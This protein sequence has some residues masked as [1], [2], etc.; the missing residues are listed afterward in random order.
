MADHSPES[1][2]KRSLT[3]MGCRFA[4]QYWGTADSPPCSKAVTLD[5]NSNFRNVNIINTTY[6]TYTHGHFHFTV[7]HS[8]S[9]SGL[10]CIFVR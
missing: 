1:S 5:T 4:S 9:E 3:V 8:Q 2:A 7:F 6:Y 10:C